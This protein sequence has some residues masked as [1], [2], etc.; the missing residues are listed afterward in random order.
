MKKT[1]AS[2][3]ET[4][5]FGAEIA[6]DLKPSDALG[7]VGQLGAGKTHFSQGIVSALGSVESV[8]SPT[9]TLVNEYHDG[10]L[11]V[12][13]FDFY[14]MEDADEVLKIG[15]D[16]FLDEPGII[17]VEWA[18]KFP[19]LMPEDTRWFRFKIEDD[20]TRTIEQGTFTE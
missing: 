11:P 12:F 13:H 3:Q 18:D 14:R 7:L 20:G 5:A 4:H 8:T 2:E 1:L 6:A 10:R 16:E 17:L 15:W 9:F 19:E